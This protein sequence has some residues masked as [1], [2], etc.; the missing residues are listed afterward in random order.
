VAKAGACTTCPKRTGNQKELFA[1]VKS[2][3]LCIDPDCYTSKVDTEWA[4]RTKAAKELG[5]HVVTAKEAKALWPW[6]SSTHMQE[7]G[8]RAL[9]PGEK[10][11]ARTLDIAIARDPNG[12][13]VELIKK[14]TRSSSGSADKK[15]RTKSSTPAKPKALSPQEVKNKIA[16]RESELA[17]AAMVEKAEGKQPNADFYRVLVVYALGA[18]EGEGVLARRG[19]MKEGA[20]LP[21]NAAALEKLVVKLSEK[22]LRGL[23]VELVAVTTSGSN[24]M[25]RTEFDM[26]CELYNVDPKKFHA[27]AKASMGAGSLID[28]VDTSKMPA[29]DAKAMAKAAKSAPK[30]GKR[31]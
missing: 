18:G 3:D 21:F 1:D 6:G 7:A 26:L 4:R 23:F 20:M 28:G 11:T 2:E 17:I 14:E 5:Q 30:K 24:R 9:K 25:G 12:H 27:E 13:I 15:K 31:A 19:L 29:R 10:A 16:S 8:F 22:T